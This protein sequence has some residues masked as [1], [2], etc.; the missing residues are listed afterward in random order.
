MIDAEVEGADQGRV[1]RDDRE[2][3]AVVGAGQVEAAGG[4]GEDRAEPVAGDGVADF[5]SPPG[6][7]GVRARRS[8]SCALAAAIAAS[9]Q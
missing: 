8:R 9:G 6:S 2:G 5:S 1:D 7:W 3:G 4:V